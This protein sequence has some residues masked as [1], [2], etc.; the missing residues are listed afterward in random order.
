MNTPEIKAVLKNLNIKVVII[1]AM[2]Q[3]LFIFLLAM[4]KFDS[5]LPERVDNLLLIQLTIFLLLIA[6]KSGVDTSGLNS[7]PYKP[8][9]TRIFISLLIFICICSPNFINGIKG[10]FAGYYY[11]Q[12]SEARVKNVENRK[13][14]TSLHLTDYKDELDSFYKK[15]H[16]KPMPVKLFSIANKK[17]IILFR[18]VYDLLTGQNNSFRHYHNIDT[19]KTP[20]SI[21]YGDTLIYLSAKKHAL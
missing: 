18:D 12:I 8:A 4:K 1:V 7:I 6:I 14:I 21:A 5:G 11:K 13:G 9:L 17:E 10:I 16:D 3:P 15:K 2:L 19:L 20:F